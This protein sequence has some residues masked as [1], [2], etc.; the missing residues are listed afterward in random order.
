MFKG[1]QKEAKAWLGQLDR[2]FKAMKY[3][4]ADAGENQYMG[5]VA[6][7]LLTGKAAKWLDRLTV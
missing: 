3:N 2:Y 4:V 5:D 7:A 6:L 1:E